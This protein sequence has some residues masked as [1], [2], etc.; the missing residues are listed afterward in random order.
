MGGNK[1]V[2]KYFITNLHRLKH[3]KEINPKIAPSRI[4]QNTNHKSHFMFNA[5]SYM[6]RHQG[7]ILREFHNN[8]GSKAHTLHL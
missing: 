4:Q 6:F 3:A 5:N 8:K 7:V 1:N 2:K